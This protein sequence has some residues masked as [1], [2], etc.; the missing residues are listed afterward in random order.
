MAIS[1]NTVVVFML[2]LSTAFMQL[3]V[4]ADARRLEVKAPIIS[5]RP[6][7][8]GRGTLEAPAEQVEST[9]PGHSPSIGHNSPPN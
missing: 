5:V 9:T 3:P 2:L 6:P 1:S 7:C 8:T 4:P